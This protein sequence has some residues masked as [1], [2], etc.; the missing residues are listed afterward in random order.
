MFVVAGY[1]LA[2]LAAAWTAAVLIAATG[3]LQAVLP[4]W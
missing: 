1:G 3:M 2:V 4:G